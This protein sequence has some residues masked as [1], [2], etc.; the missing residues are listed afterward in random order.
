MINIPDP[1]LAD[2]QRLMTRREVADLLKVSVRSVDRL[3]QS[4]A[5]AAVMVLSNVRFRV[6]DVEVLLKA[7]PS[8]GPTTSGP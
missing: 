2:R 7:T 4:G 6:E 3:R 1:N 5:L 8:T